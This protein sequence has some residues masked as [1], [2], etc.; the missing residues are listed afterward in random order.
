MQS[1]RG[2]EMFYFFPFALEPAATAVSQRVP[3]Y[4]RLPL[5]PAPQSAP[6]RARPENGFA[7]AV[8]EAGNLAVDLLKRALSS[9]ASSMTALGNHAN[10]LFTQV[11]AALAYERMCARRSFVF[12]DVLAW[13]GPAQAAARLCG[14]VDRPRSAAGTLR[15]L[16]PSGAPGK[17]LAAKPM[18]KPMGRAHRVAR[19]VDQRLGTSQSAATAQLPRR[20]LHRHFRAPRLLLEC[21]PRLAVQR[22]P[23]AMPFANGHGTRLKTTWTS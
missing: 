21:H 22:R 1:Q 20:A 18:A 23:G 8:A 16:R 11:A 4:K 15:L 5:L 7:S 2:R 3:Q 10:A 14:A 12:W 19:Y 17:P 13:I 9:M 6:T